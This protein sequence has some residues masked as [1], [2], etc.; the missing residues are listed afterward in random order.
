[1]KTAVKLLTLFTLFAV[2]QVWNLTGAS[3]IQSSI[4]QAEEEEVVE[5]PI[6]GEEEQ[7]GE[8]APSAGGDMTQ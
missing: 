6:N 2:V 7:A 5:P 8:E 1:M 4:A 3:F